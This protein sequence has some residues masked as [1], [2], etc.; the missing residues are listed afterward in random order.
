MPSTTA[1]ASMERNDGIRR[2]LLVAP[3]YRAAQRAIGGDRAIRCVRDEVIRSTKSA[4]IVDIGCG[5]ADMADHIPF[6][7]YVGFDPNPPYIAEA[8]ARLAAHHDRVRLFVGSIGDPALDGQLPDRADI[9][10]ALGV[11]HHLD[12]DLADRAIALAARLTGATGRF[13]TFDPG[14]VDSQPRTA[15]FLAARD[16]GQHVRAASAVRDLM[17]HHFSEVEV[18]IRHDVLRVPYTH[19]IVDARNR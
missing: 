12:D 3:V 11:L 17:S 9:A 14:F 2:F 19:I 1:D 6:A 18:R 5:T 13:T 8:N 7:S 10:M 16:R 15:R 4:S